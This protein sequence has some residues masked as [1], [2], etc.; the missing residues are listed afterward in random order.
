M[1]I[2]VVC[3]TKKIHVC[4]VV[5]PSAF[6]YTV[7]DC[8]DIPNLKILVLCAN[9]HWLTAIFLVLFPSLVLFK[10]HPIVFFRIKQVTWLGAA[11]GLF[12][13]RFPLCNAGRK[14]ATSWKVLTNVLSNFGII[15][16]MLRT[17]FVHVDFLGLP[18]IPTRPQN[19][20]GDF[21]VAVIHS[22]MKWGHEFG[23][24]RSYISSSPKKHLWNCYVTTD[25][26]QMK[27]SHVG[28]VFLVDINLSMIEKQFR[29]FVI[30]S[31]SRK[32]KC[33]APIGWCYRRVGTSLD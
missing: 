16:Q 11:K 10:L 14:W 21:G 33:R 1:R 7:P 32:M 8:V 26:G 28:E 15:P 20:R 24:L 18:R 9:Q 13:K 2:Y 5:R 30:P 12:N 4:V 3:I 17:N 19:Q 6:F 29:Y 27:C 31:T 25:T 22:G 23:G